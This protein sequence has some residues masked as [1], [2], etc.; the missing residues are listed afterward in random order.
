M[1]ERHELR[2]SL[3]TTEAGSSFTVEYQPIVKLD[4]GEAAGFE[5][6]VRWPHPTRGMLLP[7]QFIPLAEESGQILELGS[8]VLGQ[9]ARDTSAWNDLRNSDT[10]PLYVS[11]NV[12]ARQFR[13]ARF[14]RTVHD[15]LASS[16]LGG[17]NL[18]L[19]LTESLLLRP[20]DH[21]LAAMHELKELG[22][23][24]AI[25]DFGT[26]YSALSYLRDLPI[27]ILKIDKSFVDRLGPSKAQFALVE[28]I[29][30]FAS[31]LG[32]QIIAE[33]IENR[34]QREILYSLGCPYG[35]GFLFAEPM[36]S[37]NIQELVC[38]HP[39]GV[40]LAPETSQ[41]AGS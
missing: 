5:A 1:M 32:I 22:I 21:I 36:R 9:A 37:S 7:D 12:S 38:Q 29:I 25:D 19:E 33:G 13:D 3:Y 26:G 34:M 11:V 16:G 18:I 27:D 8:W 15:V 20:G 39:E 10:R 4:S 23:R 41:A 17:Q 2:E 30:H 35:Q 14:V 40:R 31:T 6:L 28:G 24:I